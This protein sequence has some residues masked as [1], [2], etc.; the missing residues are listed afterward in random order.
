MLAK[1][2]NTNSNMHACM[3]ASTTQQWEMPVLPVCM[4]A[5]SVCATH[6]EFPFTHSL[7]HSLTHFK[8]FFRVVVFLQESLEAADNFLYISLE[9]REE[10][11]LL[12]FESRRFFF[13]LRLELVKIPCGLPRQQPKNAKYER[14]IVCCRDRL[15][16]PSIDTGRGWAVRLPCRKHTHLFALT[17]VVLHV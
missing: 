4:Y 1:E 5:E 7:T 17:L 15:Q 3:H 16:V 14:L 6:V 11:L 10:L 8:L 2:V 9:D 13:N 12:R